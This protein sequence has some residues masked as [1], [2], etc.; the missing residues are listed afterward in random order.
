MTARAAALL[1]L[2]AMLV[3]GCAGEP[4]GYEGPYRKQ[5]RDA[6]PRLE[7]SSG[8]SFTRLPVLET[9]TREEVRTFLEREFNEQMTPLQLAGTEAAYRLFG[10]LPD[11]LELR[12]FLLDLLTEQVAG[13]YD[14]TSK[15]LYVVEGAAADVRDVTITHELMHALQDQHTRLDSVETLR[16]DNDRMVAMQAVVEGQAVL[17]QLSVM[18]GGDLEGRIPGGWGGIREMI[19]EGQEA[20]PEFAA[21]PLFL[22]ETLLFP[23]LSGAEFVRRFKRQRPGRSPFTPFAS[24]TEQILHPEKFLDSV[25]DLP[26]R[27]QLGAPRTGTVIHEDNLGEFE[28]RLLLFQ[29]LQDEAT[30]VRGAAGWDGDRYQ[31]VRVPGGQAMAWVTVWDS[32]AEAEEFHALVT[33]ARPSGEGRTRRVTAMTVDGR[34]V[35]IYEDVPAGAPSPLLAVT[36]IVLDGP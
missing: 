33:R 21:A 4:P 2:M 24:S 11:T 31:V 28:T 29:H 1:P 17:E 27:V 36:G 18:T 13:Y 10:L 32:P 9:R 20:M 26:T 15:V 16:G 34:P 6:I 3:A 19:R 23:Y 30:A 12:T 8:L 14:P 5:V 25:P 35:V 22:Q 7:A